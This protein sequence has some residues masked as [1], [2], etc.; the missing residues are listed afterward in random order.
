MICLYS[1]LPLYYLI[2]T[3]R[4]T[5]ITETNVQRNFGLLTQLFAGCKIKCFLFKIENRLR[6]SIMRISFDDPSATE[7]VWHDLTLSNDE[8]QIRN[9]SMYVST[10]DQRVMWLGICVR[11]CLVEVKKTCKESNP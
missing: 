11:A 2:P 4:Y 6:R 3:R 9:L 7:Y 10:S 1:L 8:V 5:I